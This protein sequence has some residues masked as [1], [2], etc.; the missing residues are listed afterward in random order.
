MCRDVPVTM[1]SFDMEAPSKTNRASILKRVTMDAKDHVG[2]TMSTFTRCGGR[3]ARVLKVQEN[4]KAEQCGIRPGDIVL[5]LNGIPITSHTQA[6]SI[7]D[8]AAQSG[9]DVFFEIE[10]L[11]SKKRLYTTCV[12]CLHA[13]GNVVRRC[14]GL[15]YSTTF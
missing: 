11:S 10:T 14:S 4:D 13:V 12:N 2:V 8:R 6:V 15:R 1:P 9:T 5:S 3:A 7:C